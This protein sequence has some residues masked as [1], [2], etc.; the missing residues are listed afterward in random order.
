MISNNAL[1]EPP[2]Y[3]MLD[4][5]DET[6]TGLFYSNQHLASAVIW[7]GSGTCGRHLSPISHMVT[8]QLLCVDIASLLVGYRK[9]HALEPCIRDTEAGLSYLVHKQGIRR[10]AIVGHSFSGAVAISVAQHSQEVVAVVALASQTYGAEGVASISPRSLLLVHGTADQRLS[11]YCSEQIYSWARKPKE[12][13]FM[14]GASHG[15][16]EAKDDICVLLYE[17]LAGKL[18]P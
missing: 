2:K 12:L 10:I 1:G 17:W 4:V 6:A 7:A 9:P 14:E 5:G 11:P 18:Q 8:Q 15:L 16:L 13:Y 3:V